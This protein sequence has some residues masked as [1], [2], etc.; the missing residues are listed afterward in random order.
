MRL[1]MQDFD[2]ITFDVYGTLIDWEPS[3]I[4]FLG[5]WAVKHAIP[6]TGEALLKAFDNARAEIQQERPAKLYPAVLTACFERICSQYA[7]PVDEPT[8]DEFSRSPH[9]WQPYADSHAGLIALQAHAKVGALSNIDE[10][11]LASSCAHLDFK[12]DLVVTAERVG[13][14]KPDKRQFRNSDYGTGCDGHSAGAHPACRT[15][16]ARRYYAR[17]KPGS[18]KCLDQ[19]NGPLAG[20]DGVRRRVGQARSHRVEPGGTGCPP[21]R[22]MRG[23]PQAQAYKFHFYTTHA[24]DPLPAAVGLKVLEIIMRDRLVDRARV[25]GERLKAGFDTMMQRYE[26]IGDVRGRGLL[27]GVD[28]VKDRHTKAPYPELAQRVM[29]RCLELGMST[30]IIRGE[31]GVFRIAPPI[32]ITDDEID[33]GLSIFDQAM[34]EC[35]ATRN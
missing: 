5:Q 23:R 3:I 13:A 28:L 9:T 27:M 1:R 15:K 19:S 20:L 30:S 34:R 17:Q 6:A 7:T 4:A 26:V 35:L 25:A 31:L 8:R 32:T 29:N 22:R 11:S 14:Y 12:F 21:E 24:S 16:P 2:A 18:Q 33:L 10:A